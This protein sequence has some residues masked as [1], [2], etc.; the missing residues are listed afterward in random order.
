MYDAH[1]QLLR[2][3]GIAAVAELYRRISPAD[4]DRDL[5]AIGPAA[6]LVHGAAAAQ[7]LTLTDE[8]M[9]LA[10]AVAGGDY[11]ADWR[12]GRADSPKVLSTGQLFAQWMGYAPPGVQAL[13]DQGATVA[14]ALAV[15]QARTAQAV[16]TAPAQRA[17]TTTWNRFLVDALITREDVPPALLSPWTDEVEQYANLWDG[18]RRREYQGPFE[19]WQRV[20]SPGA[21][22]F[23][24]MLATRTDYTSAD[25]AM[26]AGGGEGQTQM[27]QRGGNRVARM[28]LSGV[29][30]RRTSK[31]MSGDRYHP[32]CRCTVRMSTSGSREAA[33]SQEDYD[34]LSARGP[35]GQIGVIRFK[36]WSASTASSRIEWDTEAVGIPMPPRAPWADA[37]KNAPRWERPKRRGSAPRWGPDGPPGI[38]IPRIG[39]T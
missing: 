26:Y 27:T 10:A 37:W 15:S 11:V 14:E 9:A 6:T 23:C 17:R 35:D 13:I 30:R 39:S 24:L 1:L 34:R 4:W 21:C 31:M 29:Q 36:N 28:G 3:W 20:P 32:S 16:A 18:R 5:K 2:R 19:R 25:A 7:A 33:I 38:P 8:Y 22:D 12:R